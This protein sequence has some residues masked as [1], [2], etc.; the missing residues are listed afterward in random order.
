MDD[1]STIKKKDRNLARDRQRY[2]S[3]MQSTMQ[4][5]KNKIQEEKAKSEKLKSELAASGANYKFDQQD[6]T[7]TMQQEIE[8]LEHKVN[9]EKMR[10]ND[11]DKKLTTSRMEITR[12]RKRMGNVNL[13]SDNTMLIEKQVRVLENRLDQA[14]VQ[15]NEA[16]AYNRELRQQ[17]D[18]LRGERKVFTDIYKKLENELHEKKKAMADV[19]EKSNKDYEEKDALDATLKQLKLAA[20]EDNRKYEENFQKLDE[21]MQK[22][23]AAKEASQQQQLQQQAQRSPAKQPG[24]PAGTQKDRKNETASK[25]KANEEADAAATEEAELHVQLQ[26]LR[27]ATREPNLEVL[28]QQFVKAEEHNFSMYNYVN[29]RNAE[30]E[31]LDQ[32]IQELNGQLTKERGDVKRSAALKELENKLAA[33]EAQYEA[34]VEKTNEKKAKIE[35]IRNFAQELFTR[36]GCSQEMANDLLGTTDAT[37]LNLIQFLGIIEHRTNELLFAYNLAAANESKKR[38]QKERRPRDGEDGDDGGDAGDDGDDRPED[39]GDDAP[40]GDTKVKFVGVGPSAATGTLTA[41]A[42]FK[43]D[44]S[45][46]PTTATGDQS[47]ADGGDE[48]EEDTILDHDALRLQMEARLAQKREKEEKGN[49]RGRQGNRRR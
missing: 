15:F 33:T 14:L 42:L 47:A 45:N 20:E 39:D 41:S 43:G 22:Y 26:E 17:I 7:H 40:A 16:L 38:S 1:H 11:L 3:S 2:V 25:A 9:F 18:N 21:M 35:L 10:Q 13:T 27:K 19:I 46:L 49:R 44:I 24:S 6:K 30:V 34:T 23:K 5:Q 37:E 8:A 48:V 12:A 29:L 31:L 36:I 28:Y 4:S 32:D